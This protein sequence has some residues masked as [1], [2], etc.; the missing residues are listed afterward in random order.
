MKIEV[1]I[2]I[3]QRTAPKFLRGQ[4]KIWGKDKE[5]RERE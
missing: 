3:N 4:H 2:P 5:E 1:K